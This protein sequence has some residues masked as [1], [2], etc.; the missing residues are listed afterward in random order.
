MSLRLDTVTIDCGDPVALATFWCEALGFELDPDSDD[1]GAFASDPSGRSSG[2]FFQRVPEPKTV[3]DRIHLDV[4]ASGSIAEEVDRLLAL[5]AFVQGRV[6][7]EGS[8]W[9]VMLDP[10]ANEFC[11]LRGPQDGWTPE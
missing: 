6:E 1:E 9:T 5:G 3:K 10:E 11:V 8:F 7:V 4:R 2:L